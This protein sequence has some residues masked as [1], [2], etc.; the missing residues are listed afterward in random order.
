[1]KINS[2]ILFKKSFAFTYVYACVRGVH[3]VCVGASGGQ[4]RMYKVINS[5]GCWELNSD[6]L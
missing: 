4:K 5:H 1:M 3:S 6:L 2:V